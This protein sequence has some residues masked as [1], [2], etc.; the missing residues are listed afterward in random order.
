MYGW[1]I[2]QDTLVIGTMRKY[3]QKLAEVHRQSSVL[4]LSA[5]N[6]TTL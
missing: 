5:F 4:L 2:C 1:N 6:R 3:R